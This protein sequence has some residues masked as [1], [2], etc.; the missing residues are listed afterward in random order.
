MTGTQASRVTAYGPVQAHEIRDGSSARLA[1]PPGDSKPGWEN[2]NAGRTV[3]HGDV[4]DIA[5]GATK[6]S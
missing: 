3:V 1:V 4:S 2:P 6:R 5:S